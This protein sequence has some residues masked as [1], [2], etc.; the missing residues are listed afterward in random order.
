VFP[1]QLPPLR[2]RREDI[3]LLLN[4]FLRHYNEMHGRQVAGFSQR[5]VR[6][7]LGYR[8]PGNVRELQNLV[9]RGVIVAE[10]GGVID[11]PHLFRDEETT[12]E[13]MFSVGERGALA[14]EDGGVEASAEE[15][16]L[17][18]QFHRFAPAANGEGP[19]LDALEARL[20]REAVA[21]AGGN[22]TAAAR[23]LGLT[24]SRLA[25]RMKKIAEADA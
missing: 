3:P 15:G 19:S 12:R 6:T 20:V 21:R 18:D 25:Y 2:E 10:D 24:R 22:L 5:A 11:L 4:H 8:F 16:V 9:E 23:L 7:L 13:L 14:C 1:I 17:L